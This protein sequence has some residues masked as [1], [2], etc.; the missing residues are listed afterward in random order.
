[1]VYAMVMVIVP[2][3]I[4]M[5]FIFGTYQFAADPLRNEAAKNNFYLI[6]FEL[7]WVNN[8]IQNK[9]GPEFIILISITCKLFREINF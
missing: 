8:E 6:I 4:T 1:M 7:G 2:F 9:L 3:I 5:V